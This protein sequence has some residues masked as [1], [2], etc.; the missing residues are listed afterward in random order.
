MS[1][2]TRLCST[3]GRLFLTE[4]CRPPT[5]TSP[6]PR[7]IRDASFIEA[8]RREIA[9]RRGRHNRLGFVYQVPFVVDVLVPNYPPASSQ[10]TKLSAGTAEMEDIA[11]G[12]AGAT[13]VVGLVDKARYP[14]PNARVLLLA[15]PVGLPD[16]AH[17]SWL[18]H[19]VFRQRAVT[20]PLGNTRFTGVPPGRIIVRVKTA[21]GSIEGRGTAVSNQE[22]RLNLVLP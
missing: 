12:P 5:P 1:A 20:S 8:G 3:S 2:K 13:V 22:L 14:V 18:H 17:G 11:L 15:D 4:P 19:R 10:L 16:T 21:T 6:A 9:R 7:L